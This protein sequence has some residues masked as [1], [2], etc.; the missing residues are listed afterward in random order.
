MSDTIIKKNILFICIDAWRADCISEEITPNIWSLRQHSKSFKNHYSG[1]NGT[2]GGL[3]SIFYGLPSIYWENMKSNC[4]SPV[5]INSLQKYNYDFEIFSTA[6]LLA[7]AFD[8]TIF[9]N[10]PN[11]ETKTNGNRPSEGDAIITK[12]FN[13]YIKNH[14]KNTPYFGFL[15]YDSAHGYDYPD[16]FKTKFNPSLN[17]VNYLKLNNDYDKTEFFNRYKNA[18]NYIDS[19]IGKVIKRLKNKDLLKNTIIIIIITGD[20]AQ[21]F[22]DNHKNYWGHNGNFSKYQIKTPLMIYDTNYL[23]EDISYKTSHY[24]IIPTLM[25]KYLSYEN[26]INDYSLGKNLFS[27]KDWEYLISG[28]YM[29]F[30]IISKDK[31]MTK[32]INGDFTLADLQLNELPLDNLN[33]S[34]LDSI[35]TNM[36]SFYQ[37]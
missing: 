27:E 36:N 30:G 7:P 29:N 24:D 15:F 11:I 4:I 2:R 18:I 33:Y 20:H 23:P 5:F 12:K 8:K 28:S 19:L 26:P 22:N 37:K 16:D 17:A 13:N 31:I 32:Y 34:K 25:T 35:I 1:S 21:E 9:S 14:K 6:T 3:F 10:L